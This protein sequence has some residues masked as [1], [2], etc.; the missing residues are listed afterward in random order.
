VRCSLTGEHEIGC[1]HRSTRIGRNG[2]RP[3]G[4]PA[5]SNSMSRSEFLVI[6]VGLSGESCANLT[7]RRLG[8]TPRSL[9]G[10]AAGDCGRD[11]HYWAP[12]AQNRTGSF[13]AYGSH[14]GCLTAGLGLPY[15][16]RRRWH[17]FPALCPAR[18]ASGRGLPG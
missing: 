17:A 1:L 18:A 9:R 13:P 11:T 16:L 3:I 4:L 7:T 10:V 5:P 8:F 15:A 6:N 2:L 14:L 12:P